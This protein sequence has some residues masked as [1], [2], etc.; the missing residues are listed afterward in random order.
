MSSGGS[1][2]SGTI[3]QLESSMAVKTRES[4]IK[5]NHNLDVPGIHRKFV[6]VGDVDSGKTALLL[7]ILLNFIGHTNPPRRVIAKRVYP[8]VVH[9]E[10]KYRVDPSSMCQLF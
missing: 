9:L 3:L 1:T 2:Y 5:Y 4:L 7:Y 10:F 8:E 6:A